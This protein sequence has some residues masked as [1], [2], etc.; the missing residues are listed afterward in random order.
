MAQASTQ[1]AVGQIGPNSYYTP[2]NQV[3]TPAGLQV[4]LPGMRPQ[5]L[6]L[7]PDGRLLVTAGKTHDLVVLDPRSGKVLQRVALPSESDR[8]LVP[9]PVSSHQAPV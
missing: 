9:T 4:E 2:A 7:S 1:D 8:D 3:L 5:A 6:A